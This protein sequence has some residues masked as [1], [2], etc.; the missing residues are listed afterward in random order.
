MIHIY[1]KPDCPWCE[2][3]KLFMQ[4]H[5]IEFTEYIMG[6]DIT[7]EEILEQFPQIKTMPIILDDNRLMGGFKNLVEH[8]GGEHVKTVNTEKRVS[9]FAN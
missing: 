9:D 5:K 7:R 1:S 4:K 8:F 2:K 3:A 6:R